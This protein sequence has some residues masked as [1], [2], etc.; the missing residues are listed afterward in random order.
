M[1]NKAGWI[2]LVA[3]AALLAALFVLFKPEPEPETAAPAPDAAAPAAPAAG[4]A[5]TAVPGPVIAEL[6][7]R[8]GRLESGPAVVK[9]REGDEVLLRIVTDRVDELHLHGY[10]LSAS[11]Q[12]GIVV[13]LRFVADRAGRFEY[14]LHHSHVELGAV[15]VQPK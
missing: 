14:E 8:E 11:L 4:V 9:A 5:S 10:D 7:V 3:G 6:R 1:A 13:E 15:E 2:F 12:P